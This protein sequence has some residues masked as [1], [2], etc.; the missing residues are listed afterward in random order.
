MSTALKAKEYKATELPKLEGLRVG[1]VVAEWN[2]HITGAL[3]EG[4]LSVFEKE[5]YPAEDIIVRHVPGS[6]EL[7]YGAACLSNNYKLDAVIVIGCVIRG[8]TP[9]FD[10]V[11]QSV[12]QGVAGINAEGVVPVIFG[13]LTTENEQQ[14]LDRAGGCLGN[15]G[16][17]AAETAIKMAEFSRKANEESEF[18]LE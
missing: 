15:K 12:T 13:V 5:G 6:V 8:D 11:C 17:E 18:T 4:A 1:I 3:L 7:T 9:H 14:A 10:Y 16:A 2:S